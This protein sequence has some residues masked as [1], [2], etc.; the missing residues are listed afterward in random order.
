M[1]RAHNPNLE[2]LLQAVEH[3]GVLADEM[4]FLGGCATGLLLTDPAAPAI[5]ATRD[6]DVIVEVASRS[7]YYALSDQLRAR[8]FTEDMS[9]GAPLCRWRV[10]DVIL[11]VMPTDEKILGF[12]NQWYTA[13]MRHAEDYALSA[14]QSI[15]MVTSPYF[16]ATKIDAFHGRG[17]GDYLLSHD[18][19]DIVAVIDGRP[20]L[21][22]EVS[23]CDAGVRAYLCEQFTA[24][25]RER[26]FIDSIAG[27]LPNDATSPTRASMLIERI[28]AM[29]GEG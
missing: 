9:D 27:H 29:T 4:V 23:V 3:L 22:E 7:E 18:M 11:D 16:L 2:I 19:E 26:R 17:G 1:T 13:A 28:N 15:R 10:A 6:V 20:E 25:M 5:R 8:G 21:V 14:E 24:F 12:S